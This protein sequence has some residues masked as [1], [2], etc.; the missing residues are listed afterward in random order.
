MTATIAE[1]ERLLARANVTV[2]AWDALDDGAEAEGQLFDTMREWLP[3]LLARLRAYETPDTPATGDL[4]HRLQ[5]MAYDSHKPYPTHFVNQDGPEAA[6]VIAELVAALEDI[7]I[8]ATSGHPLMAGFRHGERNRK[9]MAEEMLSIAVTAR[10][11]L[12]LNR[13]N[14]DG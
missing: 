14:D 12:T 11:A 9:E 1:L 4:L 10:A 7:E 2:G 5:T 13:S 8:F 3:E 6:R